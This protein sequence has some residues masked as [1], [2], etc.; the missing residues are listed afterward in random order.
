MYKMYRE[1][2]NI[3]I[4]TSKVNKAAGG[5]KK[6]RLL[7]LFLLSILL[8]YPLGWGGGRGFAEGVGVRACVSQPSGAN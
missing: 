8:L 4:V 7:L 3:L 6:L 1:K 5:R 2:E